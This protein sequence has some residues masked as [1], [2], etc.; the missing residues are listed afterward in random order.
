MGFLPSLTRVFLFVP[1]LF[2]F[3]PWKP[4]L[5]LLHSC[6][7]SK[8]FTNFYV[9]HN[10]S[11][12][13]TLH[14]ICLILQMLGNFALLKHFDNFTELAF[15]YW[16]V[17]S[18]QGWITVIITSEA[19][20]TSKFLAMLGVY[21]SWALAGYV[22]TWP[23]ET[24]LNLVCAFFAVMFL[25]TS[26][27]ITPK[28]S[29]YAIILASLYIAFIIASP[30]VQPFLTLQETGLYLFL[31]IS[32]ASQL[33]GSLW[34]PR[35]LSLM[36]LCHLATLASGHS[37]FLMWGIG[38][39]GQ[40]LQGF[41]H[42]VT[43]QTSTIQKLEGIKTDD[44]RIAYECAHVTYFPCLVLDVILGRAPQVKKGAWE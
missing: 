44:D 21:I 39:T 32:A 5:L 3:Y 43:E 8:A 30:I 22:N 2:Y 41:S 13:I 20:A 9:Q 31:V 6:D 26:V 16:S 38:F 19:L 42:E 7:Y 18:I 1:T 36:T 25:F 23:T 28:A 27:R 10:D 14:F 34:W 24:E 35:T 40:M 29:V 17:L 11:A 4:L 33:P 37:V 15:P 12:N